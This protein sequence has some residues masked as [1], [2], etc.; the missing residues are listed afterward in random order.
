MV[1]LLI[2]K[3]TFYFLYFKVK[4]YMSEF[5]SEFVVVFKAYIVK[6]SVENSQ[7]SYY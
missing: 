4:R 6:H 5:I 2:F 3:N 7:L 1:S